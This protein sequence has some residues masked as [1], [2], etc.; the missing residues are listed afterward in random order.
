MKRCWSFLFLVFLFSAATADAQ[1]G[2]Y[3]K[4]D[5]THFTNNT[6]KASEWFYGPGIGVYDNFLHVGPVQLGADLRGNYLFGSK[7]KYRSLLGGVRVAVKPPLLPIRPYVEGLVGMAG[8]KSTQSGSFNTASSVSFSST[9]ST[10]F[11]YQIIGGLDWTILPHLDLR[12]AEVGYGRVSA[13]SSGVNPPSSSITTLS[14][15]IVLRL[16]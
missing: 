5:L 2:V 12:V 14:S 7:D 9:F 15:G 16:F 6:N 10:K 3:G 4:L 11:A 1:V 8:T 13:V